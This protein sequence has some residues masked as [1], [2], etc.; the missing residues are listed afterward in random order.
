MKKIIFL[1]LLLFAGITGTVSGQRISD[2]D[3]D[4]I[5]S[6]TQDSTSEFYYPVLLQRFLNGDTTLTPEDYRYLYYGNVY[7]DKYNPYGTSENEKKFL[8]LYAKKEFREALNPGLEELNDNPVNMTLLYRIMVC[9]YRLGEK[10]TMNQYVDMYYSLLNTVYYSGDGKSMKTAYVVIKVQDE[11]EVLSD[12]ELERTKQAL[13]GDT[14][15]LTISQKGQKPAKG[16]KKI[17]T[18][19]FNVS[20]S[21]DHLYRQFQKKD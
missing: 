6:Q 4:F 7:S 20:Q 3:F 19:Y 8:E 5:R 12:L 11:Y 2:I 14:D 9:Y 16:E 18:L 15:V 13:V 21:L 1:I 17:K 10:E